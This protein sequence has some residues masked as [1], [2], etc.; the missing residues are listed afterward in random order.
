MDYYLTDSIIEDTAPSPVA[1]A[2]STTQCLVE[3][4]LFIN[5]LIPIK[6]NTDTIKWHYITH[7]FFNLLHKYLE[8]LFICDISI[9][10]VYFCQ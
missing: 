10:N 5:N 2:S 4:P 1:S 9:T 3:K 6:D 8:L 7:I